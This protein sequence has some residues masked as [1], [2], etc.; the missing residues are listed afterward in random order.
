M[1]ISLP[2]L[3]SESKH[4]IDLGSICDIGYLQQMG[5]EWTRTLSNEVIGYNCDGLYAKKYLMLIII[6]ICSLCQM[7]SFLISSTEI[8]NN[9]C[10]SDSSDV[11]LIL[12]QSLYRRL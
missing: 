5:T 3:A 2:C 7:P 10:I 12:G 4:G 11:V 1:V 8:G 6:T 9:C